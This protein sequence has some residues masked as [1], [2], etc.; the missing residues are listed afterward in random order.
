MTPGRPYSP[1]VLLLVVLW[2]LTAGGAGAQI[3]TIL[4]V[5]E[6]DITGNRSFTKSDL[7]RVI[8][9]RESSWFS[10]L[11]WIDPAPFVPSRVRTDLLRIARFYQ[12]EGFLEASVDTL[13]ER[14]RR[15]VRVAFLVAEG[16]PVIVDTL[17]V[18]GLT[19]DQ[20]APD[21]SRLRTR[22]GARLTRAGV[23]DDR[24]QILS[25]LRDSGYTFAKV[26][27]R[28][29][30]E[31][32][33]R[34]VRVVV[35]VDAGRRYRFGDVV[36]RGNRNVSAAAIRRGVTFRPGRAF[37]QRRVRDSRRQLYRSGAF[38]SVTLNFPDSLAG[39]STVTTVVGVSERSLRS[40]KLGAGYDTQNRINGSVSWTHRS[41]FGGAQQLRVRT[42]ASATLSE[43]SVDL[44]QPY[45]FG[46]RNWM[47]FGVF[48]TSEDK[49]ASV[50]QTEVGGN[51]AF[52][53]N[54]ASRT[55]LL[56]ETSTGL[57]DFSTDSLFVE[58]VTQFV[59]DHRDDFLDPR[60]GYFVRLE[61]RQ[62]GVLLTSSRELLQLTGDGR[63]YHPLPFASVLASRV[64][65][66][67]IVN[68]S[69]SGE[70]SEFERFRAGGLSS[71]RGWA[72]N[73][74]GPKDAL[75]NPTGGKSKFEASV[76]LRT[77]FNRYL[78]AAIFLDAGNVHPQFN[79]FDFSA[80]EWAAG[81]GLRYLSP[82]G[83]VRLDA[84]R[85]LTDDST[86]LWQYHFS[87]GQA[88]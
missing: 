23:E 40:V 51:V 22:A 31:P 4:T 58:M 45:V 25:A 9:T 57:I 16:D 17:I 67:L 72:F 39:D 29:A 2:G 13:I 5:G 8:E 55:S 41:A 70:V 44:T 15:S 79:A 42:Q 84:G 52:E 7:L 20:P 54:I 3:D 27:V 69:E 36:V 60:E 19:G 28:S 18:E 12:D 59:D 81:F 10:W 26:G 88:F 61:A 77:R 11:P 49:G 1:A 75:G 50:D 46:S 85:R 68:L 73:K 30:V 34:R 63:W 21:R 14:G 53:R 47:N 37:E 74:L 87:I 32:E 65:G 48:V 38:R 24:L 71:V 33:R 66:G 56:F 80:F 82:V 78:G 35:T 43:V 64:F 86:D 6:V 76:E 83:P 62:K